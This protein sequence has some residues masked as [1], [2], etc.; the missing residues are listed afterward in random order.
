MKFEET[1]ANI[2]NHKTSSYEKLTLLPERY[3]IY[4]L[5]RIPRNLP[6]AS[7]TLYSLTITAK[8]ISLVC[9][10]GLAP[11]SQNSEH[12]W[13]AFFIEGTLDFSLTGIIAKLSGHL[14]EAEI[15]LFVISTYET[16]YILV[17]ES[18]LVQA[19]DILRTNGYEWSNT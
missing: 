13:R 9:P 3:S 5:D 15:P 19:V 8:E 2:V 14:A 17:K 11:E 10:E 6:K 7:T 18:K 4:S 12:G 16:D 1:L